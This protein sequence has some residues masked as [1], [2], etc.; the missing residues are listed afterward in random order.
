MIYFIEHAGRIKV[1]YASNVDRRLGEFRTAIPSFVRLGTM[2]GT[3]LHER[4]IHNCLVAHR[5]GGEWFKDCPE[6]RAFLQHAM[7]HGVEEWQPTRRRSHTPTMWDA[8]AKRLCEIISSGRPKSEFRE[9]EQ[10]LS[11]PQGTLW[12]IRYR[13]SREVSVG[14]YFALLTAS[15]EAIKRRKSELDRAEAFVSD[16]EAEDAESTNQTIDTERALEAAMAAV[17]T[18]PKDPPQ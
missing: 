7:R 1:G 15:R 10:E 11:I 2:A 8:R 17:H 18:H 16:L 9:I 13:Q 12:N 14:E 5:E 3:R 6:V 4:T